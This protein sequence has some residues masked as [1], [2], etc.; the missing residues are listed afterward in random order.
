GCAE[1]GRRRHVSVVDHG[2]EA[3]HRAAHAVGQGVTIND[4]LL[5]AVAGGLRRWL[6][7]RHGSLE[8][9]RVQVPVSMHRQDEAPGAVPNRD[10]FINI[11]LPV[12]EA[13]STQ[14]VLAVN[15]QTRARKEGQDAEELY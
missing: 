7:A 12:Q 13:D 8:P 10:S 1:G 4:L 15:E 9:L 14:C 5:G 6:E 3:I 11:E 2:L